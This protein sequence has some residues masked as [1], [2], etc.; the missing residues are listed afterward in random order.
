[1]KPNQWPA[2]LCWAEFWFNATYNASSKTTSFQAFYGRPPPLV[3][4]GETYPSNVLEVQQ[5]MGRE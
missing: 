3:D 1:M 4:R 2:L 5:L